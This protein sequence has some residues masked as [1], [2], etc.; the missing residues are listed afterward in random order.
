MNGYKGVL[1]EIKSPPKDNNKSVLQKWKLITCVWWYKDDIN[2]KDC[3]LNKCNYSSQ[4][5]YKS[6]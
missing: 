1:K 3:I 2:R 6:N 4:H 5:T